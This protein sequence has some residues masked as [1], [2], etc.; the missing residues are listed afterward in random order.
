MPRN[1]EVIR[2][3]KILLEIEASRRGTLDGLARMCSVTTRTIR[4]DMEALQ[5]VGFPLYDEKVDGR[6]HWKLSG[7][8]FRALAEVGFTLSELCAFHFSRTVLECL[9]G[10]PFSAALASGFDK[11]AGVLTPRM[12]MFLDKLPT[13]LVVKS[14]PKTR[15]ATGAQP[16]YVSKLVEATLTHRRVKMTYHSFSSGRVKEYLVEPYR[17]AYGQGALYLFAFVPEYVQMR[18]FAVERI[19]KLSLQEE[20]FN[21][22]EMLPEG[23]FAHS[24]GIHTGKPEAVEIEFAPNVAPYIAEREW[25]ASQRIRDGAG[26]SVILSLKVCL[27]WALQ[28]WVLSFGPFARVLKPAAFAERI[29][30]EIEEAREQYM[31]HMGFESV[32]GL[33]ESSDQRAFPFHE[34][35]HPTS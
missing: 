23:P 17:L 6:V 11:L 29:L 35:S 22:I 12:R 31:P 10:A 21:P 32:Q 20:H 34:H 28:S 2:Q 26:G 7:H 4:R 1:A 14:E 33:Y 15:R 13:I 8:P 25:H 18:T 24:I 27:D 3:W 5:E 16:E 19:K 9:A 30:D